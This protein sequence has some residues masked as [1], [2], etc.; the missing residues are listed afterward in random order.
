MEVRGESKSVQYFKARDGRTVAVLVRGEF[1]D[2]TKFPPFM[3]TEEERAHIARHYDLA[4]IDMDR[5]TK[6]HVT[7]NDLPL[8]IVILNRDRGSKVK[9][10]YHKVLSPVLGESKFQLMLCQRGLGRIGVYTREGE[11]L[12]TVDLRPSDFILLLEGHSIEF[13][14]ED[15]K[16][17]E[18][19]QGPFPEGGDAEDMVGLGSD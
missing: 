6:A 12:G 10:H 11:H 7:E 19:K 13:V 3:D 17:L 15:T 1:E 4:R 9:A 18:F 14:G 2:Y 8:Q 16:L 5:R